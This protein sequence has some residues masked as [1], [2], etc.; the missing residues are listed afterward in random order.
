[1]T[2]CLISFWGTRMRIL[3]L[4]LQN[5]EAPSTTCF[6]S[7]VL[8]ASSL[9]RLRRE[10]T[11]PTTA[12][13]PVLFAT[14]RINHVFK[15]LSFCSKLC[16]LNSDS[17]NLDL[18]ECWS[19]A[20]WNSSNLALTLGSFDNGCANA[21]AVNVAWCK[22]LICHTWKIN[23]RFDNAVL[24]HD[25]LIYTIILCSNLDLRS[26]HVAKARAVQ[27]SILHHWIWSKQ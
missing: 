26:K 25:R 19:L 12:G 20:T 24:F 13:G 5:T 10:W 3:T 27:F 7:T 15:N 21:V 8:S 16:F 22:R 4:K 18:L 6:W 2:L 17:S 1:M 14:T 23:Y 9:S 11:Q